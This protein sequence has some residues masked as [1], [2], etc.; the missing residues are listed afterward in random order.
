MRPRP[1]TCSAATAATA[2]SS[3]SAR[4][5]AAFGRDDSAFLARV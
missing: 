1:L 5:G 2:C 3:T 4:A